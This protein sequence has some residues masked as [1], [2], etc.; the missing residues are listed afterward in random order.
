VF[1]QD[2]PV[3]KEGDTL[4]DGTILDEISDGGV[5]INDLGLVAFHG[6]SGGIKGV[7]TQY[8]LVAKEGDNLDDNTTLSEILN[9]GGVAI[10]LYNEVAFHAKVGGPNVVVVGLA[11]SPIR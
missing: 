5:A 4:D 6:R 8:G 7:F 1:T 2:G 9:N 10:N 11:P 3:V